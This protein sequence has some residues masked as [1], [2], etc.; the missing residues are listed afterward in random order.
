MRELP[1]EGSRGII[2]GASP[3]NTGKDAVATNTDN[4]GR[5]K[6]KNEHVEARVKA[7]RKQ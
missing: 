1:E 7:H 4:V 5:G 6:Q 3:I 2:T